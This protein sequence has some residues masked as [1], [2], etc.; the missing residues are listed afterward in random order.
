MRTAARRAR[1]SLEEEEA[2]T[3]SSSSEPVVHD[4]VEDRTELVGQPKLDGCPVVCCLITQPQEPLLVGQ[5][6]PRQVELVIHPRIRGA[7]VHIEA[8]RDP[9]AEK[10]IQR[11]VVPRNV[12]KVVG[13][14]DL[15][16]RITPGLPL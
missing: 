9:E 16:G 14:P 4:V 11:Y 15:D 7:E 8:A 1:E 6:F 3:T 12:V 10:A 5:P 2:T 13:R